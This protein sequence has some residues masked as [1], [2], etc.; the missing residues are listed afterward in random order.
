MRN[1]CI[2]KK[3]EVFQIDEDERESFKWFGHM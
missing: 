2:H 3:L 1:E